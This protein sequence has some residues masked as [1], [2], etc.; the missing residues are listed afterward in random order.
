[1]TGA[2]QGPAAGSLRWR[3]LRGVTL[4][5]L[6]I[7]GAA[8][9]LSYRAAR[10][11]VQELMDGQMTKTARLL[12]A[13]A[14]ADPALLRRLPERMA[15]TRGARSRR[16]ELEL[17]YQILA[18]D[19]A[20]LARSANAPAIPAGARLGRAE[21][22]HA[23]EPWRTLLVE[24]ADGRYR[25]Q[26]AHSV[27]TRDKEALEIASKTVL[28]MGLLFP[29]MLG[30]IYFAVR[31]GLKPLDDLASD[32]ASRSPENLSALTPAGGPRETQPL[33]KAL[34]RLL[35]RVATTLENER[36]FTTDA[37][38]ELRTPLAAL[39]V[40]TQVAMATQDAAMHRHALGQILAGTERASRVV[41]QLLRLAR[42]DPIDKLPEPRDVDLNA[43][44]IAAV[45]DAQGPA[46]ARQQMLQAIVP[47]SATTIS[48]DVELLGAALR[49]LVDN[50]LRHAPE[51][52]SVAVRVGLEGG[53]PYISVTDTG[54]GVPQEDLPRLAERFYR[55]RDV[56]AEGSGLG[57]AIVQ[58]IAELHGARLEVENV[59]GGGFVSRLRW[60]EAA[61]RAAPASLDKVRGDRPD[62]V[63]VAESPTAAG[64]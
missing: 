39:K 55:G 5:T 33:V 17:E 44:A 32:V 56:T 3:L 29:L 6:V 16:G 24:S 30:A 49:N 50:A 53:A 22:E 63:T 62:A 54:P 64:R 14:S 21:I 11:E 35:G 20:V 59:A 34:N 7:W 45:T 19:G 46:A 15:E 10:H 61:R 52:S 60:R 47:E 43:V 27:R 12:L 26:V 40:Q 25:V 8:A 48:G 18:A 2:P 4:T 31:R 51:R 36:R 23:G 9:V 58:R 41:E 57:L 13:D 37:A 1:M 28:P 38:H 42:L